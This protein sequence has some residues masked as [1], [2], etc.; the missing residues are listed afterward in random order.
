MAARAHTVRGNDTSL[1]ASRS[2]EQA[3]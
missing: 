1:S 2:G 3:S